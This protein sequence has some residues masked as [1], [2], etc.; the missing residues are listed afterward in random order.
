VFGIGFPELLMILVIALMVIGPRRLPE[1]AKALGRAM[2][3][4]K[5]AT[6]EFKQSINEETK[7]AEIREQI[8]KGGKIYPPEANR[9]PAMEKTGAADSPEEA[10]GVNPKPAPLGPQDNT[11]EPAPQP[12]PDAENQPRPGTDD[13]HEG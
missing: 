11:A 8:M 4:F 7:A 13:D 9:A 1:I 10:L 2:G 3:E 6:D 5:R 12:A